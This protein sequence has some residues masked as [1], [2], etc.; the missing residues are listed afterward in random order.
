MPPTVTLSRRINRALHQK[1]NA[2]PLTMNLFHTTSIIECKVI[3]VYSKSKRNM[4]GPAKP[5]KTK[6]KQR[7]FPS[8]TQQENAF[9]TGKINDGATKNTPRLRS[10]Y[11]GDKPRIFQES[12]S[13]GWRSSS[14]DPEHFPRSI[15]RQWGKSTN[16]WPDSSNLVTK[17]K[18]ISVSISYYKQY[19]LSSCSWKR[20]SAVQW[21]D[22]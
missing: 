10:L 12:S 5:K 14:G 11:L 8:S 15:Y 16:Y 17:W 22:R 7:S 21:C 2:I 19:G 9:V 4:Q 6:S 1:R 3:K 20:F 13:K 18:T